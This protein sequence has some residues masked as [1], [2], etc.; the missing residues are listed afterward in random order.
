MSGPPDTTALLSRISPD[1]PLAIILA[2]HNGSG[3]ST[4]WRTRLSGI[5]QIPLINAD[6]LTLSILPESSSDNPRQ[7]PL[8]AAALRDNDE[9]WQKISQSAVESLVREVL[10]QSVS[11]AYETVFSHLREREDGTVESKADRIR[12]FQE[13]GYSVVLLFVGLTNSELSIARV[14]TRRQQGGHAVPVDKL[15]SR[16]PRTQKVV[17]MASEIADL[18]LMFD[19]SRGE[20]NAFSLVR[21][22]S[23]AEVLYDCRR[24]TPDDKDLIAVSDPW[25]S[26]VAP[27]DAEVVDN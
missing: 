4:L 24:D 2:G 25:L 23:P 20:K 27:M 15:I 6:R 10:K 7:L 8:W 3:K 1:K 5:L 21:A 26:I 19:N 11:F 14:T 16:F 13:A 18:T 22:Q 9:K 12:E 17:R